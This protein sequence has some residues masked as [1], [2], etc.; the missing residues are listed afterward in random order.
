MKTCL[1]LTICLL[2]ASAIV[3]AGT[4]RHD[5]AD[6]AYISL[7]A[8][9]AFSSVGKIRSSTPSSNFLASGTLIASDW[10]LT[11]AHV[12]DRATSLSFQIGGRS[13]SASRWVPHPQWNGN[14]AAGFDIALVQLSSPVVGITPATRYTGT[15]ELGAVGISVGFGKT[16]QGLD[17]FTRLDGLKRA[18][19]NVID[20]FYPGS[21]NRIFISDFDNPNYYGESKFGSFVPTDLEYLIAPGDSGGG[22]FINF[23]QGPMLAGVHSFV[24][25]T[26]GRINSDYGDVSG[27]TR[28]SVFNSWINSILR[29]SFTSAGLGKLTRTS[30]AL[31][32]QSAVPEPATSLLSLMIAAIAASRFRKQR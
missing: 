29:G 18:G 27:H 32:A 20:R 21:N 2:G 1:L 25:A 3:Q 12:V 6:S 15:N 8:S 4:I 16:G 9:P 17:G 24:S 26:D 19:E 14:L 10:I 28:V 23:G 7:A 31:I 13:Y 22:V 5:R 11:A 30:S